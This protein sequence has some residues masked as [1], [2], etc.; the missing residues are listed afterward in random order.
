[1]D[2]STWEEVAL[3]EGN[4]GWKKVNEEDR[5]KALTARAGE[6][7]RQ[8]EKGPLLEEAKEVVG[9]RLI[10]LARAKKIRLQLDYLKP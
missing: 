1:M 10:D 4:G 2:T 9:S 7:R 6:A 8:G 5:S 3:R